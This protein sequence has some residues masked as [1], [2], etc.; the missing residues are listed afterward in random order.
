MQLDIVSIQD[1]QKNRVK[2]ESKTS[3]EEIPKNNYFAL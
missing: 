2:Q 3:D 1:L